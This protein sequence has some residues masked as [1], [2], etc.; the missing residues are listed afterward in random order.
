MPA[1]LWNGRVLKFTRDTIVV[2]PK[3]IDPLVTCGNIFSV[4]DV[5]D[6]AG[7][8]QRPRSLE[9]ILHKLVQR[10][11][12]AHDGAWTAGWIAEEV[13][14]RRAGCCEHEKSPAADVI[15]RRKRN[16]DG[17]ERDR[18]SVPER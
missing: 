4:R 8:R 18:L 3:R 1:S 10:G 11:F 12:T 2:D 9:I 6:V 17:V 5:N 13:I 7:V 16:A 14:V 15:D